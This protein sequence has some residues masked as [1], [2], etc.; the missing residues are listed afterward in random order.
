M[1]FQRVAR[2]RRILCIGVILGMATPLFF[3]LWRPHLSPAADAYTRARELQSARLL[4]DAWEVYQEAIRQDPRFAPSYR[5]L[6]E[7]AEALRHYPAAVHYW[8]EFLRHSPKAEHARCRLARAE[9]AAGM[10]VSALR[11]A[12]EELKHDPHCANAHLMAGLLYERKS[13]SKPALEH[14]AQAAR[15]LPNQ[16][17]ILLAYGRVLALSGEFHRAEQV[18]KRVI[19]QEPSRPEPYRWLGY[20]YARQPA[21]PNFAHLAEQNLRRALAIQPNYAEASYELARLFLEQG[22]PRDALPFAQNAAKRRKHY[23]RALYVLW[24]VYAALGRRKEA[25]RAQRSFQKENDLA[26][27]QLALMKQYRANPEDTKTALALGRVL[28]AREDPRSALLFLRDAATRAPKDA[29]IQATLREAEKMLFSR[30]VSLD[31][32]LLSLMPPAVTDFPYN[33]KP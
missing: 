24:R 26:S 18:L 3:W 17:R 33:T 30:P 16:P 23:P 29:S 13:L 19:E 21:G 1:F 9:F 10:E 32:G 25:E 7:I 2:G 11:H 20:V 15:L 5:G 12:E 4:S 31:P 27:R 14:L 8:G 22:R 28:L 6:A